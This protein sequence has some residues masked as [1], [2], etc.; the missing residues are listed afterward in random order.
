MSWEKLSD[1]KESHPLQMAE[2]AISIGTDEPGFNWW[3]PHTLKK[4]DAIID[5]VKKC[6]VST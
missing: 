4:S 5:L 2:Y 1:L 3:V 6:S